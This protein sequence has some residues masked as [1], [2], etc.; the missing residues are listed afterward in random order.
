M[1]RPT[2]PG[3]SFEFLRVIGVLAF[4]CAL[5][6]STQACGSSAKTTEDGGVVVEGCNS[7]G[8]LEE[9]SQACQRI[10]SDRCLPLYTDCSKTCGAAS[11]NARKAFAECAATK[12][13]V[14]CAETE[15]YYGIPDAPRVA[16]ARLYD[17]C[18]VNCNK[19]SMSEGLACL[20][21]EST[22]KCLQTCKNG[23]L[24]KIN[25][26]NKCMSTWDDRCVAGKPCFDTF[27]AP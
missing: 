1:S 16:P 14:D 4:A 22:L 5:P 23:T 26:F 24:D 10:D 27:K 17:T 20:D 21:D 6:L 3:R 25:G 15:C 2:T 12:T 13:G 7:G 18:V 9:C 19:M 11:I 8:C